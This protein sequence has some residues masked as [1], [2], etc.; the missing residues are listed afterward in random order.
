MKGMTTRPSHIILAPILFLL[1]VAALLLNITVTLAVLTL[2]LTLDV[3]F[4][5][6][7]VA[8]VV[9]VL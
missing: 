9:M 8:G 4:F 5:L 1:G 7:V 6:A 3:A 2:R